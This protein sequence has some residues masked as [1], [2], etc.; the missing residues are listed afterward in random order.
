[1]ID[2][3]NFKSVN[4]TFGHF[5]GDEVLRVLGGKI[6]AVFRAGD[7]VGR[8]GGDEYIVLMKKCQA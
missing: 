6:R 3:D 5:E 2:L 4:D 7:I 8:L 1:M